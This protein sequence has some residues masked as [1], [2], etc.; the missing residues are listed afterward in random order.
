MMG[1][2]K[3]RTV[4]PMLAELFD[5]EAGTYR[6]YKKIW[7]I[8]EGG[9]YHSPSEEDHG[10]YVRAGKFEAADEQVT[11]YSAEEGVEV[12]KFRKFS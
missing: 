4:S 6:L 9:S 2:R 10:L 12:I 8:D 7:L 5:V 11:V 1:V 3:R